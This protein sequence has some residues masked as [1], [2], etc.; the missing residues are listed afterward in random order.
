MGLSEMKLMIVDDNVAMRQLIRSV[1]AYPSDFVC[2]CEDGSE[3]VNAFQQVQP[4]V[5]L[6]DMQMPKVNGINA[7]K[8]LKKEFPNANV[9]IVS[10]FNDQDFRD[11]ARAAGASSYFTKDDLIQLKQFI[12]K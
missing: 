4:D 2:E 8:N 9:I 10:N 11:E 6:M 5:V 3:V 7:T 12:H 1:V